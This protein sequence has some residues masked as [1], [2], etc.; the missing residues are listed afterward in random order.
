MVAL[1][2][3]VW[4]SPDHVNWRLAFTRNLGVASIIGIHSIEAVDVVIIMTHRDD[5]QGYLCCCRLLSTFGDIAIYPLIKGIRV[6]SVGATLE[7]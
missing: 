7:L 2:L 6:L 5:V 1:R 3:S 4:L